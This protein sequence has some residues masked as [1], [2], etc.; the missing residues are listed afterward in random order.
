[1]LGRQIYL[2]RGAGCGWGLYGKNELYS[3]VEGVTS[4]F[5]VICWLILA[6]E[7]QL[8]AFLPNSTSYDIWLIA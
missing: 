4:H 1:M 7:S 8:N 6:L 5:V 2:L 3:F